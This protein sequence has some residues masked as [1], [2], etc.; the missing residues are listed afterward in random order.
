MVN[1]SHVVE[2]GQLAAAALALDC[3]YRGGAAGNASDDP[4]S[5]LLSGVGN[6][7]GIRTHGRTTTDSVKF[8]LLYTSGAEPDWPDALDPFTGAFTYFGD[9]R[10]PGRGLHDTPRKGNL[11][12]RAFERAHAGRAG[13]E[14]VPPF[15]LFDKPGTGRSLARHDAAGSRPGGE[16]DAARKGRA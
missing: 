16:R 9:N 5:K 7:G 3:V 6:Q 4:L 11:L 12:S 8:V 2:F 14:H 1:D 15:F 13:R 10:S